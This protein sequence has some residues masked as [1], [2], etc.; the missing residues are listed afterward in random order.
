MRLFSWSWRC[1][2][3]SRTTILPP[4][5]K[6]YLGGPNFTRGYYYGEVTGDR[7][8]EG[9]VEAQLVTL[10][11]SVPYTKIV[12]QA[13]FY[14][15]YDWGETWEQ[16]RTDLGHVLRSLGGGVR[17]TLGDHAEVDLEGVS[18]L[19]RTPSASGGRG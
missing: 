6:F 17:M 15:F 14:G 16:Q 5:E 3:S 13:T 11:P 19:T 4:E 10:L 7:A 8:L 9:K 18:R 2:D 1:R 12:P